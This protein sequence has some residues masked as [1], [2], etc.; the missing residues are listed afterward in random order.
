MKSEW[1]SLIAFP[2]LPTKFK[3]G[4][5]WRGETER[6]LGTGQGPVIFQKLLLSAVLSPRREPDPWGTA[7][8]SLWTH[9]HT[10]THRYKHTTSLHTGEWDRQ[11]IWQAEK[12]TCTHAERQVDV[13]TVSQRRAGRQ[14]GG[15]GQLCSGNQCPQ[16]ARDITAPLNSIMTVSSTS[17]GPACVKIFS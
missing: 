6:L 11:I 8:A 13:Q 2:T 17:H 12:H 16:A 14:A 5:G 15:H 7:C 1:F 4:A 9:I 10:H 3:T